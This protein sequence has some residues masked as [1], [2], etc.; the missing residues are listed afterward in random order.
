MYINTLLSNDWQQRDAEP[1]VRREPVRDGRFE[2]AFD[3]SVGDM[4]RERRA[5]QIE[6]QLAQP[7]I[8]HFGTADSVW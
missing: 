2:A 1:I 7:A 5:V 6:E 4:F 3:G 8:A